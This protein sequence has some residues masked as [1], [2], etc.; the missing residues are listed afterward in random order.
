MKKLILVSIFFGCS[1]CAVK[2]SDDLGDTPLV[3]RTKQDKTSLV[4]PKYIASTN[5]VSHSDYTPC[6]FPN[7][8]LDNESIK[9]K[10]TSECLAVSALCAP[11]FLGGL[12][13]GTAGC[14]SGALLS[15]S[16]VTDTLFPVEHA[17]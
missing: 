13:A 3:R 4:V 11:S 1:I 5:Q 14:L 6:P 2:S 17:E 10:C 15:L 7:C 12:C 8:P 16:I 9:A